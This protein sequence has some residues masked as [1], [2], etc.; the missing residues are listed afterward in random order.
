[1]VCL[2]SGNVSFFGALETEGLRGYTEGTYWNRR[3][4]G[5][6]A[7]EGPTQEMERRQWFFPLKSLP[8]RFESIDLH[9][10]SSQ[11]VH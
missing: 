5:P 2:S 11:Y 7:E 8:G 9:A 10:Y 1:M 6:G 3:V 4:A